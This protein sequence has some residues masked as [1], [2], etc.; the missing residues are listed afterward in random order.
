M[1]IY[2]I[3]YVL[4]WSTLQWKSRDQFWR[5]LQ[6]LRILR[7][8]SGQCLPQLELNLLLLDLSLFWPPWDICKR[9]GAEVYCLM[10]YHR[11]HHHH[12]YVCVAIALYSN[13]NSETELNFRLIVIDMDIFEPNNFRMT[14]REYFTFIIKIYIEFIFWD[15][16][17]VKIFIVCEGKL[18]MVSKVRNPVSYGRLWNRPVMQANSDLYPNNLFW[19]S[20]LAL[21]NNYLHCCSW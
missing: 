11:T 4:A 9:T 13:N 6:W 1:Q 20:V 5:L 3:N 21:A 12:F 15:D 16:F 2:L 7:V 10:K 8:P 19:Y 17:F 18:W 14:G